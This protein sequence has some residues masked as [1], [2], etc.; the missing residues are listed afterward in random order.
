MD[1]YNL[2][3]M[4]NLDEDIAE[5][6]ASYAESR[7]KHRTG[8]S[9]QQ[10]DHRKVWKVAGA[11]LVVIT[12]VLSATGL[13]LF[14]DSTKAVNEYIGA[15]N[16]QYQDVSSGKKLS[17]ANVTLR[18]VTLGE[19]INAKYSRAKALDDDY[20]KL[21][22]SLRNYTQTMNTHN[23]MVQ[24]F[25]AG[26]QGGK[27]LNGD[28]LGLAQ[29]MAELV[30]DDYPEQKEQ[31]AALQNLVKRISESTSFADIASDTNNVL[32]AEDKWLNTEREKIEQAR[33]QFQTSINAL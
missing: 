19:T 23:Q 24:K 27:I 25:N 31:I 13:W 12:A 33:E 2:G 30:Q 32:H 21:I 14:V 4:P 16:Q 8:R 17:D 22:N 28:I 7:P 1:E 3:A 5:A 18:A 29:Q 9:E 6:K 15:V 11:I 10:K 26:L 20:Q